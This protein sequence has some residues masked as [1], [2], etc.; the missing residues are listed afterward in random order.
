MSSS[1]A[2]RYVTSHDDAGNSVFLYESLLEGFGVERD[3]L[4]S[5]H[6]VSR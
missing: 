3:G 5:E 2:K 1:T 6:F 4:V